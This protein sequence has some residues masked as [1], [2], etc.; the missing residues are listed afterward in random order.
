MR[1]VKKICD[2]GTRNIFLFITKQMTSQT[3]WDE[4]VRFSIHMNRRPTS[5]VL[6]M[7]LARS[8]KSTWIGWMAYYRQHDYKNVYV[9]TSTSFIGFYQAFMPAHHVFDAF[10]ESVCQQIIDYKKINTQ[11]NV[12]IIL[13]DV[14]D[15]MSDIRKSKALITLFTYGRHLNIAL[16]VATQY[17]LALPPVF[18]RNVDVA[19]I[20]GTLTVDTWDQQY[21]EYGFKLSQGGIRSSMSEVLLL[22]RILRTHRIAYEEIKRYQRIVQVHNG[23]SVGNQELLHRQTGCESVIECFETFFFL[24]GSQELK[25]MSVVNAKDP[26]IVPGVVVVHT[27]FWSAFVVNKPNRHCRICRLYCAINIHAHHER[28]QCDM[29][30]PNPGSPEQRRPVHHGH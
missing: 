9:F 6:R 23:E 16:I 10:N 15:S 17:P 28:R 14:L 7:A 26:P 1:L 3:P 8:G 25:H 29:Q 27:Y 19:V 5:H 11:G 20:F 4:L 12:M 22:W 30:V 21:K 13:D 2:F 24:S 18:R